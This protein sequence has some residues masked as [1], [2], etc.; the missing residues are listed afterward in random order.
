MKLSY[1][2]WGPSGAPKASACGSMKYHGD[3]GTWSPG[4][5]T[6]DDACDKKIPYICQLKLDQKYPDDITQG[7]ASNCPKGY[8]T[9]DSACYKIS[10]DNFS[11]TSQDAAHKQCSSDSPGTPSY[12]GL[13]TVWN[14]HESQFVQSMMYYI[15]SEAWLGLI[16]SH[17]SHLNST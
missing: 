15:Q 14:E 6:T 10:K 5:W 1:T 8:L 4:H 13:V 16:Y 3:Y 11:Q 9:F 12:S 2:N 17:V 7:P